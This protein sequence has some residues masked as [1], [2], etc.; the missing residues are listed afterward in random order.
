MDRPEDNNIILRPKAADAECTPL[1]RVLTKLLTGNLVTEIRLV[2]YF[3]F[4]IF[5]VLNFAL[6]NFAVL[7]FTVLHFAVLNGNRFHQFVTAIFPFVT[8]FLLPSYFRGV[9]NSVI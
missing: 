4:C 8:T 2:N 5:A 7:N 1:L 3:E 9:E 6:L